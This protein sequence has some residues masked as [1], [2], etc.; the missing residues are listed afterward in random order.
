MGRKSTFELKCTFEQAGTPLGCA[1]ASPTATATRL[2]TPA[3]RILPRSRL[4]GAWSCDVAESALYRITPLLYSADSA[5][6]HDH[7]RKPGK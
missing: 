5:T 1:G 6:S 4:L 2:C 3:V 7:T